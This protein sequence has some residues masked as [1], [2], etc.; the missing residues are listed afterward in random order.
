MF[1][2]GVYLIRRINLVNCVPYQHAEMNNCQKINFVFG[3]NGS[4]K[5]TISSLLSGS[6]SS[7]FEQSSI[8]WENAVHETIY[9]YNRDFR[10]NNFKQTIPG[11]FT[12]GSATI[13]EINELDKLKKDLSDKQEK[14]DNDNTKLQKIL[15]EEIP[16]LENE[17]KEKTWNNI[18]KARED[19]FQKAFNGLRGSKDRFVRELK[20][21]IKDIPNNKVTYCDWKELEERAR[22]LYA[23]KKERCP[24]FNIDINLLLGTIDSIR[25]NTIWNTVIAGNN[26]IDLAALI[27]E[28]NISTWVDQGRQF[29][30]NGSN[31]CPFCQQETITGEFRSKLEAFFDKEYNH[32]I[33]YMKG[34]L[35]KYS[36][37]SDRIIAILKEIVNNEVAVTV[38][39]L[40]KE[41]YLEKLYHL[42]IKYS[43]HKN[44]I[45]K[46]IKEPGMRV[47]ISDVSD[48]VQ[49][50][51]N[52]IN[53]ANSQ[54]NIHNC[55]ADNWDIEVAR[56]TDDVWASAIYS[57]RDFINEYQTKIQNLTKESQG[58]K[59]RCD[60]KLQEIDQTKLSIIEKGKTIT[61]VQP[62]IDEINRS[63]KAYGFTNF[64]IQPAEGFENQYCIL[65]DDGSLAKDTLSEGEE[66]FL[67]F[68]YFMQWTKGAAVPE[69]A[70]DKKIIVLDDPISSL[71][72]TILYIVG[73]MVK[74]LS[75][76]IRSGEGDVNQLFV[77][78]HNVFF[79]KEASFIDVRTKGLKEVNYWIVRKNNG[80]ST[81]TA[82][83]M[84]NPISTAYELLWKELRD[85]TNISRIT[86]QNTMRRI[87]ENY[88][89][90]LGNRKDSTLIESFTELEEQIIAKS[91][92]A[93]INDGSHSIP[94][95]LYIDSYSDA[96]P[97]YKDVFRQIFYN[98]GHKAHYDMMM[99]IKDERDNEIWHNECQS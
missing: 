39:K 16:S 83:G 11:V 73:A 36:D 47:T 27:N 26:D 67:T 79:H 44:E 55:I 24:Q 5:S 38:G 70:L 71:D 30:R 68:L 95:D 80:T 9:V 86:I 89:G 74:E 99:G 29:I 56:L 20:K 75:R 12:I 78:T 65:R 57:Q 37:T 22:T 42:Q 90:M 15:K 6:A 69:H 19:I 41:K 54:I 13:D 33:D 58:L 2:G 3:A 94:D 10:R 23:G 4:G 17:F 1:W 87:I 92:I 63:L 97:K 61:S 32:R 18:L 81:V 21:R 8:E 77:L 50:I 72:S 66:T 46:K 62:T 60:S 40:N 64:S 98:S 34:L 14:Y 48:D 35:S 45:C 59:E 96:V 88:F 7:R 52:F 82:Y 91:L 76:K 43:D 49:E 25:R 28:L 51:L 31:K 85:N 53:E 84:N 93:W